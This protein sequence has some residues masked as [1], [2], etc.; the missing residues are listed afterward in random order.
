MAQIMTAKLLVQALAV[1]AVATFPLGALGLVCLQR[2]LTQG[3]R[4][5]VA[6][7]CGIILGTALWCVVVVQGLGWLEE[8]FNF[9]G[10]EVRLVVGIFLVFV[11][12]RNLRRAETVTVVDAGSRQM[13]GQFFSTLAFSLPNPITIVT[14]TAVLAAF[15]IG[16]TR[17]G[18]GE[19][20]VF[21]VAVFIG[22]VM[23]WLLLARVLT[24]LRHRLGE[25]ATRKVRRALSWLTL[26]VGV[27]YLLSIL[28]VT[29]G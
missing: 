5:G 1:G 8:H 20:C 12:V 16:G 15:G 24:L 29:R 19:A 26:V 21:A 14:V 3:P 28:F 7:A 4:S 11:A 23:L 17:L 13:A 9:S 2:I 10:V 22:G 6:S 27:G 25:H 18:F